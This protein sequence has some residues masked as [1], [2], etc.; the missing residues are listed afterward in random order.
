[1]YKRQRQLCGRIDLQ[2]RR[3]LEGSRNVA[4]RLMRDALYY[5][6]KA[7]AENGDVA[8]AVRSGFG[9]DSLVPAAEMSSAAAPQEAHL[10]KL[11]E[12]IKP[13][14]RRNS[15]KSM[16]EMCRLINRILRGWYGYFKHARK[17]EHRAVDQWVR[18][19]LRSILR[20]RKGLKGTGRGADHQRWPIRYFTGL[21][22]FCLEDARRPEVASLHKGANC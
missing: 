11:R 3:L 2:I 15:G 7:P 10:R 8:R 4:E 14:T 16:E 6:A 1:M 12:S 22:L 13:L 18:T 19:R 5:V 21:G 17:S 9:L 20:K